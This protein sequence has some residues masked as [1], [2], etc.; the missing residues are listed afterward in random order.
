MDSSITILNS[1]PRGHSLLVGSFLISDGSGT[2]CSVG[3]ASSIYL[4][5]QFISEGVGQSNSVVVDKIY[6]SADFGGGGFLSNTITN[7]FGVNQ[8]ASS[9]IINL[10][11]TDQFGNPQSSLASFTPSSFAKYGAQTISQV[12]P[13]SNITVY[14]TYNLN[15]STT[16]TATGSIN[17]IGTTGTITINYTGD[18]TYNGSP[19]ASTWNIQI[20]CADSSNNTSSV[21]NAIVA[22]TG[23]S[24]TVD[25]TGL[26]PAGGGGYGTLLPS[27]GCGGASLGVN[28]VSDYGV[29]TITY[30]KPIAN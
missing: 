27:S 24:H 1:Y 22:A 21:T 2:N 29:T 19:A 26:L 3:A 6:T 17:V 8:N 11:T 7:S 25:Y 15:G 5:P 20:G 9:V 28:T 10:N 13:G 4:Q 12:C 14:T 16:T 23:A 18:L 30:S